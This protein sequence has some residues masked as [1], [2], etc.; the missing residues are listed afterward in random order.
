LKISFKTFQESVVTF[1]TSY[2]QNVDGQLGQTNRLP[3]S[4]LLQLE[5]SE[6]GIAAVTGTL[7]TGAPWRHWV[8]MGSG[9]DQDAFWTQIYIMGIYMNW[10]VVSNL[11]YFP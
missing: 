3:R 6:A 4:K 10:L 5:R 1:V 11:F 9:W 2:P 7:A 8:D